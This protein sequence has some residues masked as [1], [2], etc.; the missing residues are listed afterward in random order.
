MAEKSMCDSVIK[1][2]FRRDAKRLFMVSN[3]EVTTLVKGQNVLWIG[4]CE[5]P[6]CKPLTGCE[7]PGNSTDWDQQP[8]ALLHN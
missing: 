1:A 3:S 5:S 4:S 7:G 2:P 8:T 6:P